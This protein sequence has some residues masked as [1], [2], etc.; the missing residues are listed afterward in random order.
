LPSNFAKAP[1]AISG[2]NIYVAWW[3]NQTTNDNDEV[4]FRAFTDGDSTF[5]DKINL[6]NI[7]NTESQDVEIAAFGDN[8]IATWWER[9]ATGNE[10]VARVSGDNGVTFGPLLKLST[11]GSIGSG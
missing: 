1:V 8:V 9:I 4:F 10:P 11:N 7:T 2:D 3:T 6:S 5:A